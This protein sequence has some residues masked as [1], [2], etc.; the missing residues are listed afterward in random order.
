MPRGIVNS[1]NGKKGGRTKQSISI[2]VIE[3]GEVKTFGSKSE[4]SDYMRSLGYSAR[5][6]NRLLKGEGELSNLYKVL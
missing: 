6:F 1:L 5:Q 2:E 4:C 3:S